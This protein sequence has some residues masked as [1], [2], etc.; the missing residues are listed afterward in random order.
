MTAARSVTAAT[1]QPGPLTRTLHALRTRVRTLTAERD[2]AYTAIEGLHEEVMTLRR[3]Q[4][5]DD[6]LA[7]LD[8]V[9]RSWIN[10]AD[11]TRG[12]DPLVHHDIDVPALDAA[13]DAAAVR[14]GYRAPGRDVAVRR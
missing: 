5:D 11:A 12:C 14:L 4:G 1:P 2:E 6:A 3:R 7:L 8:A 10:Y 9:V 13:L